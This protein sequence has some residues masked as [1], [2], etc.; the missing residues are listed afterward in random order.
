MK[1]EMEQM[2]FFKVTDNL[3][4]LRDVRALEEKQKNL[5]RGI[6]ARFDSLMSEHM[7]LEEKIDLIMFHLKLDEKDLKEDKIVELPLFRK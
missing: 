3:D 2:D 1:T 5:R 7:T 4:I 6:F